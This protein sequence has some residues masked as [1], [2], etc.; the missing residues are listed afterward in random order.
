[1]LIG[2]GRGDAAARRAHEKA[3]LQQIRLVHILDCAGVLAGDGRQRVQPHRAAAELPD[4]CL[5][6]GAVGAVEAEHIDLLHIQRL[7]RDVRI[8]PAAALHLRVVAHALDQP[9]GD[10]GRAARTGGDLQRAVM[11]AVDLHDSGRARYDHR[12]LLGR[13]ELQ[14]ETDA[15]AVAQRRG[16]H[17]CA[18][19][20]RDQRKLGQVEPYRARRRALADHDV[21]R[22]VLHR[23]IEHLLDRVRQAVDLVYEQHVAL[24][25][26]GQY[27]GQIAGALYGRAGGDADVVSHLRGDDAG[28]RGLAQ[29]GRAVEQ[30]VIQRLMAG[31]RRLHV[32]RQ[33]VLDLLLPEILGQRVRPERA[34]RLV[35]AAQTR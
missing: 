19:R 18:R 22:V 24:V 28:Q 27:A 10:A 16:Q 3:Q 7:A 5:Q 35:L 13:V 32:Y 26:V 25:E 6:H 4:H 17:A 31:Q 12:Q 30:Y 14:P 23:R 9:V 1:M 29:T 2:Q 11:V 8:D 34:L 33:A 15:E 20:G 21:Q